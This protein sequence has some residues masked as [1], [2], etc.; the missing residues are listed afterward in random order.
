MS[1]EDKWEFK[2]MF[3]SCIK[4]NDKGDGTVIFKDSY[5]TGEKARFLVDV[6]KIREGEFQGKVISAED[7]RIR[8][9][10]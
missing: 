10:A 1:E 8:V 4:V 5:E 9:E 3:V 7:V 6:K 2:G